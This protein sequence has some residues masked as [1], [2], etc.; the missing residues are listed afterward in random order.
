MLVLLCG[1]VY[2]CLYSYVH[3]YT[4]ITL[5]Q[6]HEGKY[7]VTAS[8]G[9]STYEVTLC[10]GQ[11]SAQTCVPQCTATECVYL[12]RHQIR[13]TCWDY[14]EGHLC[15]HC[16]KVR[17]LSSGSGDTCVG[18]P[19]PVL[20]TFNPPI[21]NRDH[22]G[23]TYTYMQPHLNTLADALVKAKWLAVESKAKQVLALSRAI[24]DP[25]ILEHTLGTLSKLASTLEVH[26]PKECTEDTKTPFQTVDSFAPAQK[27]EVQLH[28]K[29]TT[30]S[31][32][33]KQKMVP[34][35]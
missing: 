30:H 1:C 22:T 9:S 20:L 34:L 11:C 16:H 10:S 25:H 33:R 3:T 12:C 28:F 21:S 29:R 19:E 13:C 14:K 4:L 5:T 8:D 7:E 18:N 17:A 27:N 32:G 24:T 6:E 26:T 23:Y 31:A 15:K 35:R 2:L